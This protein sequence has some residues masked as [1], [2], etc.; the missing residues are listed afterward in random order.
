[1]LNYS[2]PRTEV[3][4]DDWPYGNERVDCKFYIEKGKGKERAVRETMN[5]KTGRMNKPKK[6]TYARKVLF[7]DGSDGRTYIMQAVGFGY[8]VMQ[9]NMKYGQETI[10]TDDCRYEN[11]AKM[12]EEA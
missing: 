10:S 8:S 11:I 4:I 9:G 12:F 5:P 3:H 6:L 7:V 2:N 1:M